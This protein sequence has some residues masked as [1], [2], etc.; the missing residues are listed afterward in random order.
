M[1][2]QEEDGEGKEKLFHPHKFNTLDNNIQYSVISIQFRLFLLHFGDY[3]G[4]YFDQ[5]VDF[6]QTWFEFTGK[7]WI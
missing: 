1:E 4:E 3:T 7:L 5:Y 2:E 6:F